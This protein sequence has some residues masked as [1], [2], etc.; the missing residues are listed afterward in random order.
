MGCESDEE[1]TRYISGDRRIQRCQVPSDQRRC[2]LCL[3]DVTYCAMRID[4]G[5]PGCARSRPPVLH[6][7]AQQSRA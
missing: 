7:R 2:S 4:S 1:V 6:L 5:Q 3:G